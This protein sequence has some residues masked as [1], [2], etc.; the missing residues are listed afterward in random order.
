MTKRLELHI[1]VDRSVVEAFA[2]NRLC[3]TLRVY[4]QS[5]DAFGVGVFSF[6]GEAEIQSI[7][8]WKLTS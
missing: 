7:D 1:F 4:P 8:V 5:E 3:Q 2:N 6:G